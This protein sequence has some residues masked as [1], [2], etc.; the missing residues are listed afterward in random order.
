MRPVMTLLS[1]V[2]QWLDT[3]I[4]GFKTITALLT[5]SNDRPEFFLDM[6]QKIMDYH[7]ELA[8]S[9]LTNTSKFRD[10]EFIT[11][12]KEELTTIY[13][14][15]DNI[16]KL[17]SYVGYLDSIFSDFWEAGK[18]FEDAYN[19]RNREDNLGKTLYSIRSFIKHETWDADPYNFDPTIQTVLGE[20]YKPD[21]S[22]V[23]S[24]DL[25]KLY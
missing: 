13:S 14:N 11:H 23:A 18:N 12:L 9:L 5:I 24:R 6:N 22:S 3:T 10:A 2:E 17:N 25:T 8:E 21:N 4:K 7:T 19:Y 20:Y 15:T 1:E 16:G